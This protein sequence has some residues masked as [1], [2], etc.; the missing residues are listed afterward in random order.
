M[1]IFYNIA[2]VYL[3]DCIVSEITD[4]FLLFRIVGRLLQ[5]RD[6]WCAGQLLKT[7]SWKQQYAPINPDQ[8]CVS[9]KVSI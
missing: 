6:G 8:L 5:R 1:Y 3:V 7:G 4:F 2:V 9:M